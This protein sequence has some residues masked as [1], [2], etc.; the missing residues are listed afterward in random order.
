[1]IPLN[2]LL[3]AVA[4]LLPYSGALAAFPPLKLVPVNEGAITAPVAIQNAA[5]G[6]GRLF[7]V[8]QRGTIHI[9]SNGALLP[10]P[11]LDIANK[12]VIERSGFDERGLLGFAFH[13]DFSTSAAAGQGKFYLY[14]S[15]PSPDAPGTATDP[16]DH[17]SVIAEYSVSAGDANIADSTSE[18]ILLTINE[19]QFN[20]DA[21]QLAFGP[22]GMLY[23]S[24]GDGGSSNDNNA[25]HTGGSA[26]RPNGGLGNSQ[27][28]TNLLGKILRLDPQGTNGS[29][30]EFGI[31]NDNPFVGEGGGVREEIYAYGLRNPWRFSFDNGPGGTNRLFCADVGQGNVEEINLIE[32]GGNYGWRNKEGTFDFDA[33]AAGAGPIIDPVA[34]YSHPTSTLGLPRIGLSVTGGVIYR[35]SAI[36]SL[37]GNYVFADWSNNFSAPAGTIL[38]LEETTPGE[39]DL[40]ILV[41]EGGNPIPYY[42]AA[43]GVDEAGEI[44]VATKTTLA[45]SDLDPDTNQPTG[46]IFRLEEAQAVVR[47]PK[48]ALQAVSDGD[49]V[50]PVA[51]TNAGD[52]T[53]R[54]FIADQR[55][56]IHIINSNGG[57]LPTLFLDISNKLVPERNGFDERGLLGLAFHPNYAATG[58]P[59]EGKFYV[60]YSAPSPDAPG[61]A[62]DPVDHRSVIA[63]YTASTGDANLADTNSERVLFTVN[64]PQFNHDAGQLAFGNDNFL[65]I[66]LGDGGSSNDNN[67]GH[68]G[69]G[70]DRPA[71][72]LGNSQ[73]KTNLLGKILRVD[74]LGNN[75]PGGQFGVPASNPFVGDAGGVREEIYAYGLRNPWRFSFDDGPGGTDR[76]FC[77]D[78]GQ[79]DVEEINLITAGKNYGW[80]NKEGI[81]D[82]APTAPGT[83]PFVDPV[84]QYAHPGDELGLPQIGLSVTGGYVYRG[85]AIPGLIGKYVFADWSSDFGT[86]SGTLLALQETGGGAF[87]L[88]ILEV[89]GGNPIPRYIAAFGTDE[90]GELYVATKTTLAPSA[91]DPTTNLP[92]GAIFKFVPAAITATEETVTLDATKDNS[93][94]SEFTTGSNG[95]GTELFAGRINTGSL[96]RA[97]IQFDLTGSIPNGA[98]I[99]AANLKMN[100]NKTTAGATPV[101]L[102]CLNTNWGEGTSNAPSPGGQ[103]VP[104]ATGDATWTSAFH[105]ATPW[106]TPGG[107]FVAAAS[108]TTSVAGNGN[109]TWTS[110]GLVSDIQSFSNNASSNF[111]WMIRAGESAKSAK[112]FQS[113]HAT[114]AA[115]RPKLTVSYFG[116]EPSNLLLWSLIFNGGP[117]DLDSDNDVDKLSALFE[118]SAG[119]DPNT[120][121]D[122]S[123]VY[124][125]NATPDNLTAVFVRDPRATDLIYQVET[126][127]DLLTWTP[128]AESING[129]LPSGSAIISENP[130][131]GKQPLRE[132]TV[133]IPVTTGRTF[134]R[135]KV[136]FNP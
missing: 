83:G 132:T 12:L 50:A 31:P 133:K 57:V 114:N 100:M 77:A 15:A 111:G 122:T 119:I 86:P 17:M 66:S 30:G 34:Q 27:D 44:Y 41:I 45:P 2:R 47:F 91:L 80:R 21:G 55:G 103:G 67:A 32:S 127:S 25:G 102:H 106:T 29:G 121:N 70:A 7:I 10:T 1:M 120:P 16:V 56:T 94:Y 74:P 90:S 123:D 68:T 18:R 9:L 113:R 11:F 43:F 128:I 75:G 118:Y 48:V 28:R 126:S 116:P 3:I 65:Y 62:I 129:A 22:D 107:D 61:T 117:V 136:S 110:P 101:D 54:L 82:F 104:A 87:A 76:L 35:G 49:I 109:Y 4:L 131:V 124:T 46:A 42:I 130:L 84:A 93:I 71:N 14:Y 52:G 69:G 6:S 98:S 20:H 96:R 89:D 88:G 64:Q 38:G 26:A 72:A 85:S 60:Y 79:G 59:G 58:E 51:I 112:R 53:N 24:T 63:E 19:P 108:A 39:F 81:F 23:I 78:V 8:D 33:T 99:T 115:N 134:L 13:P 36:P 37:V 92:T 5:D 125:L 105:T 73:D 135:Y 95:L 97:L 40:Q